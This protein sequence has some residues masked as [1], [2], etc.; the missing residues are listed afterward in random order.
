MYLFFSKNR[1]NVGII[2]IMPM[3]SVAKEFIPRLHLLHR[4]AEQLAP[5]N[6]NN[7]K[8]T[9]KKKNDIPS[10]KSNLHHKALKWDILITN[11]IL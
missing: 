1:G 10:P 6:L 2:Q 5:D 3:P 7:L 9:G 8:H 11:L 4:L